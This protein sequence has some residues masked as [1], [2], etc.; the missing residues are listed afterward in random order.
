MLWLERGATREELPWKDSSDKG[1]TLEFPA[2][3]QRKCAVVGSLVSFLET[4]QGGGG[5]WRGFCWLQTPGWID[6]WSGNYYPLYLWI[7]KAQHLPFTGTVPAYYEWGE[8]GH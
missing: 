8:M 4:W 1:I 5:G 3:T 7:G 2:S 6:F